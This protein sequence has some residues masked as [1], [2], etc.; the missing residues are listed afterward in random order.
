MLRDEI[1]AIGETLTDIASSR[2]PLSWATLAR[3]SM[4]RS[5]LDPIVDDTGCTHP[6]V[7]T[8]TDR[9]DDFIGQHGQR[10]ITETRRLRLKT[11][12]DSND[13]RKPTT[14]ITLVT[15]PRWTPLGWWRDGRSLP[16]DRGTVFCHLCGVLRPITA[17]H[18]CKVPLPRPHFP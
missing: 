10:Q 5:R 6:V 16:V 4:R 15:E 3:L 7:R 14:S 2:K 17:S 1:A 11:R 8:H 18:P 9:S 12:T 13:M